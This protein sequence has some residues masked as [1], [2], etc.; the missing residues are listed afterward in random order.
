[1]FKKILIVVLLIV[2]F[3][4]SGNNWVAYSDTTQ[5]DKIGSD[6]YNIRITKYKS[7]TNDSIHWS[8]YKNGMFCSELI[9]TTIISEGFLNKKYYFVDSCDNKFF[10]ITRSQIVIDVS[11][12]KIYRKWMSYHDKTKINELN[13]VS[14]DTIAIDLDG[15]G[16][17]SVFG[18]YH[19]GH[20]RDSTY[21][22]GFV[23]HSFHVADNMIP[24]AVKSGSPGVEITK[25]FRKFTSD[26]I[27]QQI[28]KTQCYIGMFDCTSKY[29]NEN[30][31]K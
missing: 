12:L 20:H 23:N 3:G 31:I 2:G 19:N 29:T 18:T 27:K 30:S 4:F 16:T 13:Y 14:S 24:Y 21:L 5:T 10:N 25:D 28:A 1:M 15:L 8:I 11:S 9:G 22:Y 26:G 6:F 7:Q 17:V